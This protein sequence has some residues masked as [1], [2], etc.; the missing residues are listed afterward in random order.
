M[1]LSGTLEVFPLEEV[2]R[3]VARSHTDGCLRVVNDQEGRIYIENGS[4]SY[5]TV[6]PD[7]TLRARLI[8]S[9]LAT[10]ETLNRL[11]VSRSP[12]TEAL[13]P[14]VSQSALAE[15]V[16]E[17]S[18]EA[19]YRIRKPAAGSFEF[20]VGTH[21]RYATGQSFD[22]ETVISEAER[23][24]SE[25]ADIESVVPDLTVPWRM[26]P[27]LE[28]ESVN[29]SDTAWRF[30]AAMDGS[31]AVDALADRLGITRF[32][33]ARRMAE[34]GRARLVE[35]VSVPQP[36]A[37][38]DAITSWVSEPQDEA[39]IEPTPEPASVPVTEEAARTS[40]WQDSPA[41]PGAGAPAQ[42]PAEVD[43]PAAEETT[44][45][46]AGTEP[47]ESFLETVF[48]ELEKTEDD[49]DPEASDPE[50]DDDSGFGLLRRRGL[51]AAFRELA[52]S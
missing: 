11:D 38:G 4:L 52:D 9:G 15:L 31:C 3:L 17:Q 16:R 36:A 1:S 22:I 18:V 33:T 46:E 14:S 19:L 21:P 13:S 48:G 32:Q 8:A 40:W 20:L 10:E 37:G 2:L 28:E 49:D 12:L 50:G 51:G 34:L 24:A 6:E 41:T 7:E 47:D 30:L 27:S 39:P 35:P 25:W 5:A 42:A 45:V 23:R 26:V 29:L 43:A 44:E